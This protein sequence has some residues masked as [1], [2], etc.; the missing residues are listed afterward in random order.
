MARTHA[1]VLSEACLGFGRGTMQ[2]MHCLTWLQSLKSLYMLWQDLRHC[3]AKFH[4]TGRRGRG[5]GRGQGWGWVRVQAH[6][7]IHTQ[8]IRC[9]PLSLLSPLHMVM[10]S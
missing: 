10:V 3:K 6:A 5:G 7:H 1:Y 9:T 8:Y 2:E 4:A